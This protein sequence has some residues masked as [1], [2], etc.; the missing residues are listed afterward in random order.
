MNK[1]IV[2]FGFGLVG[3]SLVLLGVFLP[4]SEAQQGGNI[5][6]YTEA[7]KD[8]KFQRL[9]F[10]MYVLASDIGDGDQFI[11]KMELER[12]KKV[13]KSLPSKT[14]VS[15]WCEHNVLGK[16]YVIR[17]AYVFKN[18]VDASE[19]KNYLQANIPFDKISY[20]EFYLLENNHHWDQP[21][22][23]VIIEHRIFGNQQVFYQVES[24]C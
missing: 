2:L 19:I 4:E 14:N 9:Q 21:T 13:L 6:G 10:E 12:A 15:L 23:D 16:I 22:P 17:G 1:F 20:A 3:L 5:E 8:V 24:E 18:Q 11:S 7:D